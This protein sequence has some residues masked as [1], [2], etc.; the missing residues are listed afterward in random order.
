MGWFNHQLVSGKSSKDRA[1]VFPFQI[2][3]KTMDP[4]NDLRSSW[5]DFSDTGPF[6]FFLR[7]WGFTWNLFVI[8]SSNW[9]YNYRHDI[10]NPN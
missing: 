3:Y 1:V 5:D 7:S 8:L 9:D 10:R 2:A 4:I 6:C